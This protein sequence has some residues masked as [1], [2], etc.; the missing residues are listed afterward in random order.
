[1]DASLHPDTFAYAS[2]LSGSGLS[3]EAL[4]AD[5]NARISAGDRD[6]QRA[7]NHYKAAGLHIKEGIGR[8]KAQGK[9]VGK[10]I[11][12]N[13]SV[14]VRRAYELVE[15]A[16]GRTTLAQLR[17]GKAESMAKSRAQRGAQSGPAS[18]KSSSIREANGSKASVIRDKERTQ[19]HLRLL[20]LAMVMDAGQL[21]IACDFI[22]IEWPGIEAKA[23]AAAGA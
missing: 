19:Q 8:C 6:L 23:E 17:A 13:L 2:R 11:I 16:D 14:G 1:M 3:L 21:Q 7:E 5:I 12:E 18:A 20:A 15:I 22:E 10:W 4:A 9:P